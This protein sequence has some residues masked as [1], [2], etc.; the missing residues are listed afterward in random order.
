MRY[1][2][3]IVLALMILCGSTAL[4]GQTE[5]NVKD[6]KEV[7]ELS[8]ETATE[9]LKIKVQYPLLI[10]RNTELI[11][12][13]AGQQIKQAKAEKRYKRKIK[14]T[15]IIGILAIVGVLIIK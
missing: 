1:R 4:H 5:S 15:K 11:Q 7:W 12:L 9:L 10:Q 3:L 8:C 2:K 6:C 14:F 13:L